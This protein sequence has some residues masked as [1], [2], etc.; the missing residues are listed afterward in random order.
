MVFGYLN[1]N[2]LLENKKDILN[3]SLAFIGTVI[4]LIFTLIALPIQNIIGKYSQDLVQKITKDNKFKIFLITSLFIFGFN[5]SLFLGPDFGIIIPFT[6]IELKLIVLSYTFTIFYLIMLFLYINRVYYLL[7]TRNA[8]IDVSNNIKKYIKKDEV[9]EKWLENE[10]AIIIDIT[11]KAIQ[12]NRFEI[13]STGFEEIKN[14][15]VSYISLKNDLLIFK[16]DDIFLTFVLNYLIES[17]NLVTPNSHPKIIKSLLNCSGDIAKATLSI[18]IINALKINYFTPGFIDLIRIIIM[19]SE[20]TRETSNI[21]IDATKKL[22]EIGKI[23]INSDYIHIAKKTINTL[24][25]VNRIATKMVFLRGDLIARETN[26]QIGSLL[27]Y[28]LEN[29]EKLE[30]N[31]SFLK[32]LIDVLNGNIKVYS[33]DTKLHSDVNINT[34][35]ASMAEFSFSVIAHKIMNRIELDETFPGAILLNDIIIL[36]KDNMELTINTEKYSSTTELLLNIYSIGIGL[37]STLKKVNNI[38]LKEKIQKLLFSVLDILFDIMVKY[39]KSNDKLFEALPIYISF[40]GI[41]LVEDEKKLLSKNIIE[42][43]FELSKLPFSDMDD[44]KRVYSYIR[45]VGFWVNKFLAPELD[46]FNNF[47]KIAK[48]Q[49]VFLDIEKTRASKIIHSKKERSYPKIL[50]EKNLSK[51]IFPYDLNH[52]ESYSEE[53]FSEDEIDKFEEYLKKDIS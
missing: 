22:F 16:M 39:I 13:V 34:L 38:T 42:N 45:L 29:Y 36:L 28:S 4:A 10:M 7:D 15:T 27:Y 40:I 19:S 8:L 33:E 14:I 1:S 46:L 5:F 21:P 24:S 47:K 53:L 11:Q 43:L 48:D 44:K 41:L 9:D 49:D 26:H 18:K 35:T 17:R 25:E 50:F 6:Q 51:P 52:L 30:I 12:E 23:A 2:I 20:M 3:A 32:Y 31:K 37:I